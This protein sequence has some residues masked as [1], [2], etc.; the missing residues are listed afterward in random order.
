[1][2]LGR[3]QDVG[4]VEDEGEDGE[5]CLQWDLADWDERFVGGFDDGLA[6]IFDGEAEYDSGCSGGS[7]PCACDNLDCLGFGQ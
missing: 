6:G 5:G 2:E 1:M 7:L 3:E 4:D